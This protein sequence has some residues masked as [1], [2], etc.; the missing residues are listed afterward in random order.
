M[1]KT[2]LPLEALKAAWKKYGPNCWVRGFGF[3]LFCR[4]NSFVLGLWGSLI[5]V[6]TTVSFGH[7]PDEKKLCFVEQ[8]VEIEREHGEFSLASPSSVDVGVKSPNHIIPLLILC[9]MI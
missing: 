5:F 4:P 1:L 2:A 6:K 7:N 3:S 8:E 9:G